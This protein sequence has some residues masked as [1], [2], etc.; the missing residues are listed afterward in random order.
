MTVRDLIDLLVARDPEE[1]A[2]EAMAEIV[3]DHWLAD[4]EKE[5]D[6]AIKGFEQQ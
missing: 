2:Q 3:S 6:E 4:M 5:L 1:D